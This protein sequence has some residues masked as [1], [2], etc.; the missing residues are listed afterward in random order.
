MGSFQ[1]IW[2]NEIPKPPPIICAYGRSVIYIPFSLFYYSHHSRKSNWMK[3]L[4]S[5][6]QGKF[7]F[8]PTSEPILRTRHRNTWCFLY[9]LTNRTPAPFRL[10]LQKRGISYK[11]WQWS[12]RYTQVWKIHIR[13]MKTLESVILFITFSLSPDLQNRDSFNVPVSSS[14]YLMRARGWKNCFSVIL[15]HNWWPV[16]LVKDCQQTSF[17]TPRSVAG[18]TFSPPYRTPIFTQKLH[19]K[20]VNFVNQQQKQVSNRKSTLKSQLPVSSR[21]RIGSSALMSNCTNMHRHHTN[22]VVAGIKCFHSILLL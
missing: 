16:L 1:W 18:Q 20:I 8:S 13:Y 11:L 4:R 12:L 9:L 22:L 5:N 3:G 14:L 10:V 7:T 2:R 6:F 21:A 17:G 15:L 19:L